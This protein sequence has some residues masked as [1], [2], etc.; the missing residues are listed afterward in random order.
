MRRPKTR[1]ACGWASGGNEKE[2]TLTRFLHFAGWLRAVT[3]SR[4]RITKVVDPIGIVR[5]HDGSS[6]SAEMV[7]SGTGWSSAPCIQTIWPRHS[8]TGHTLRA[9]PET[10]SLS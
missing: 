8:T 1:Q 9:S 3:D 6:F 2:P 7:I 4:E 10:F 5:V